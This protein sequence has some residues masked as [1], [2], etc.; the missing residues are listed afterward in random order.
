MKNE[1]PKLIS[2]IIII[3]IAIVGFYFLIENTDQPVACTLEAKICPDGSAVGRIPP[4]CE[5]ATCP[6]QEQVDISN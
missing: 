5:F 4:N 2:F 3:I 6:I 1:I